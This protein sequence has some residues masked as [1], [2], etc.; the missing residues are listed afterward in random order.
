M[1]EGVV[2]PGGDKSNIGGIVG[3]NSGVLENC[4]FSGYVKGKDN[5]GGLVGL[6][7]TS[8]MIINSFARGVIY[9]ESK[10]GGVAG[11]NA[12]LFYAVITIPA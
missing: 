5:I 10:V 7:G 6:N 11:F 3:N 2:T 1:V 8:G 4:S 9:G 12:G